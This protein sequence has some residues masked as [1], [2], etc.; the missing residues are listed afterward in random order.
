M[1]TAT[2]L[3][4]CTALPIDAVPIRR[5]PAPDR[6]P[7]YDDE[8]RSRWRHSGDLRPDVRAAS[9][10]PVVQGTL[11][12]AFVLPS[13]LP[14][15]PQAPRDARLVDQP[16]V[17]EQAAMAAARPDEREDDNG[18][19]ELEFGPQPTARAELPDPCPWAGRLA[20]ALVE[21][22]A[23]ERPLSQLVRWTTRDVYDQLAERATGGAAGSV[24]SIVRSVHL[25]EPADGVAE[26]AAIVRRGARCF[27]LALRLEGLDGRWQC[28]ALEFG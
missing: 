9:Q 10:F 22:L 26:V 16:A 7:P 5:L 6:E 20:Q 17:A 18:F 1:T 11:P 19:D 23:G 28:S 2:A 25:T 14:A 15:V 13:G 27:A 24:R 4:V 21:V 3:P 8:L 12:L